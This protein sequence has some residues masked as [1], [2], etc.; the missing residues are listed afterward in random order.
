MIVVKFPAHIIRHW[1][2]RRIDRA[3]MKRENDHDVNPTFPRAA[4]GEV[5]RKLGDIAFEVARKFT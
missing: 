5:M 3:T 2:A 1:T 4:L